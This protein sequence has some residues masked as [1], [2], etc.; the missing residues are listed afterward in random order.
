MYL[1]GQRV[2]EAVHQVPPARLHEERRLQHGHRR[3]RDVALWV[4]TLVMH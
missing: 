2:Q 3:Q 4:A 1:G